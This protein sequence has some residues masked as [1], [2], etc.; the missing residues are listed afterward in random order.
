MAAGK[1]APGGGTRRAGV[2]TDGIWDRDVPRYTQIG[3]AVPVALAR[4]IGMHFR[5]MLR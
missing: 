1:P 2:P 5:E 4:A 3:N